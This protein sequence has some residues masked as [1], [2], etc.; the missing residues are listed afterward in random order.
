[1]AGRLP[2]RHAG[3]VAVVSDHLIVMA[4]FNAAAT[5]ADVVERAR[6]H[7]PVLVVDDGSSD[8]SGARAAAAGAEVIALGARFGRGAA[9]RRGFAEGG[10]R[11]VGRGGAVDGDRRHAH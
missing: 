2:Y 10:R 7:G 5:I 11:W 4:V 1:R 6:L 3:G 9:L 8:D